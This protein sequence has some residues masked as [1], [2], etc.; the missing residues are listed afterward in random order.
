[1]DIAFTIHKTELPLDEFV[2]N[3]MG[4]RVKQGHPEEI[5]ILYNNEITKAYEWTDGIHSYQ[6]VFTKVDLGVQEISV[7]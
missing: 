1:M 5:H 6:S 2:T 7:E 4:R 3:L